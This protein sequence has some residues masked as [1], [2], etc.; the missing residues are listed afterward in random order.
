MNPALQFIAQ[1]S[2][3]LF[4]QSMEYQFVRSLSLKPPAALAEAGLDEPVSP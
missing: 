2:V 1:E 3:E 4:F